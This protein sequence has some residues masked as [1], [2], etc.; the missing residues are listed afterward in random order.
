MFTGI[1]ETVGVIKNTST[2]SGVKTLTIEAPEITDDLSLGDSVAINGVCLTVTEK[3]TSIFKVEVIT[4]TINVTYL[5]HLKTNDKVNLE[6]AMLANG[7]FGGHFVSGHVDG[8]GIIKHISKRK[9]EWIIEISTDAQLLSQ[10]IDKGSIT[11]DGIS[12]TIFKLYQH[13]FEIHLIPETRERTIFVNK[14]QGDEVHIETDLLFK[15]VQ[16]ITHQ[17]NSNLSQEK[18]LNLGF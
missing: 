17:N 4:G 11:V 2:Q 16:K 7:R 9:D 10:M 8:K 13:K 18:L 1:I 12:L 14:K 3:Q 6:R 5:E 15:Y